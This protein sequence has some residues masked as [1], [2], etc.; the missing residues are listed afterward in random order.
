[1][2]KDLDRVDIEDYWADAVDE[3]VVRKRMWSRLPICLIRI[4]ELFPVPDQVEESEECTQPRFD[5]DAPLLPIKWLEPEHADL[6]TLMRP[7]ENYS[8]WWVDQ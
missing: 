3:Y 8:H 6:A 7:V 4:T 2:E 1:M 5:G